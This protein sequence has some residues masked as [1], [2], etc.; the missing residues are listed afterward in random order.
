MPDFG[1]AG[2]ARDNSLQAKNKAPCEYPYLRIRIQDNH[3]VMNPQP[4]FFCSDLVF[5]DSILKNTAWI[6]NR[7]HPENC[8]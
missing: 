8:F 1:E 3:S 5:Q 6:G 7:I 2:F 4:K